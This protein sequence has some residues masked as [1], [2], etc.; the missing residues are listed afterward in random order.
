M[1]NEITPC[2]GDVVSRDGKNLTVD[3]VRID[4][5]FNYATKKSEAVYVIYTRDENDCCSW[6][7]ARL[8]TLIASAPRQL[9]HSY[10]KP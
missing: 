3:K 10:S 1:S 6:I 8:C 7:E 4:Q 9:V 5:S 2:A